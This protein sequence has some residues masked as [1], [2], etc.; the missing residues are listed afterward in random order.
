[1]PWRCCVPGCKGYDEAKSMGVIFHGLPTRDP[2]RCTTWLQAIRNP[3][4]DPDN[5]PVSKYSGVRVCSLHFQ[6]EDY[7]EDFRAKILN[8]TPKPVLKSGAV[9]SVFPGRERGD[10]RRC[11]ELLSGPPHSC[12]RELLHRGVR[13]PSGRQL[14]LRTGV[15]LQNHLR[16]VRRRRRYG[17]HHRAQPQPDG[18]VPDV[19]DVRAAHCGEGGV[20]RR[21][22]DE[23]EVEVS[24]GTLGGVEVLASHERH[25][26][27]NTF[28][29]VS[30]GNRRA[31]RWQHEEETSTACRQVVVEEQR[32]KLV[33]LHNQPTGCKQQTLRMDA[34]HGRS[35]ATLYMDAL[36]RRSA[37]T[38]CSVQRV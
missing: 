4:Y 10:L 3:R 16:R 35:A 37:W 7:E 36:Q 27:I 2:Q 15:R 23:G 32:E 17:P 22:T 38:L 6:P 8:I 26:S 34:L 19:S 14:P 1:M 9:P 28:L 12:R 13:R 11:R 29:I 33:Q 18:A 31:L 25:A 21:G 5:T 30:L 24:R 20:P